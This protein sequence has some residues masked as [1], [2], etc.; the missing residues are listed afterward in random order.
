MIVLPLE[1]K[2]VMTYTKEERKKATLK[3]FI[4]ANRFF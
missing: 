3:Y 4:K 1:K 2:E